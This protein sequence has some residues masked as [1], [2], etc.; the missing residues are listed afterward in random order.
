M[1]IKWYGGNKMLMA[2]GEYVDRMSILLHKCQKIG[3]SSYPEFIS[4]V[5]ELLL[6]S[7]EKDLVTLIS[8]FRELYRINN[9][10]WKLESSIR[11][12]KEQELGLEECGR[13]AVEIRNWNNQ[14]ITMQNKITE[15]VGGFRNPNVE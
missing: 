15:A 13:R 1:G 12:N 8:G 11:L 4:F 14:R 2:P 10:I 9:E 7:P 3:E 5:T 6:L